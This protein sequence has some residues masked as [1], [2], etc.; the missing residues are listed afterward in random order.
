VRRPDRHDGYLPIRD[1][2]A[3]G[4]R[5]TAALVGLDGSIDW[6]CLPSFD[7]PPVFA[8]LLDARRGGRFVLAPAGPFAAERRYRPA[9]NVLETEFATADGRVRVTDALTWPSGEP[10]TGAEVARV[11]E[12]LAGRVPMTW[13]VEPRAGYAQDPAEAQEEGDHALLHC[14]GHELV[15]HAFDAGTPRV[16]PAH[17]A[18]AFTAEEGRAAVIALRETPG[19]LRRRDGRADIERRL[20][21]TA[22]RWRA[23]SQRCRA[24]GPWKDALARSALALALMIDERSGAM[25]AAPTTSLPEAIGGTRNFDYRFGWLRDGN[26]AAD[27]LLRL[28]LEA[29]V[30]LALG[31]MLE[32]A[33]RS[34]KR[35]RPFYALD[36]ASPPPQEELPLDGY[37]GSRPALRGNGAARQ[38]Q[39]GSYGHLLETAWLYVRSGHGLRT[40]GALA[41]ADAVDHV[42]RI[43][44]RPDA[45]LWELGENR[46]RTQS[47]I[48][49]WVAFDRAIRLAA[50]GALPGDGVE[51]WR[52]AAR[53]VRA[54]V[55]ERC[56][57]P[58]AAAYAQ[59]AGDDALDAAVLLMA[60]ARFHAPDD[61]RTQATV[62]AI[63][64]GLSAGGPLLY[65]YSGMASEEGAFLACSFWLVEAMALGG[66]VDSAAGMMDE[67]VVLANDVGLFSEEIDSQSSELLGNFPQALTHLALVN[68]ASAIEQGAAGKN[69]SRDAARRPSAPAVR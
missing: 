54:F 16:S 55:E 41:L 44:H 12:G 30:E 2:A 48:G 29:D 63:R 50:C 43:W 11:V 4:D 34:G 10:R 23:W 8:R 19:H 3:I 14:G 26:L 67:L 59:S 57:S 49:C 35:L 37:R 38:L 13:S 7:S 24:D 27:A 36:G 53:D 6:M 52:Q 51:R 61:A 21:E 28:G 39:L 5:H 9:T 31:W 20:E 22:R 1:Y 60:R 68:A 40:E 42:A 56:W 69:G 18:G 58:R 66:N 17:V 45:G 47:H 62:G 32:A 33:G 46:M 65:R 25:V 15:L 64:R